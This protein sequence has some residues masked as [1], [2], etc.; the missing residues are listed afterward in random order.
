MKHSQP[1]VYWDTSAIL[2]VLF[3]D[4][5][6]EEAKS[7]ADQEGVHLI[8]SLGYSEACAVMARIKREGY[9]TDILFTSAFEVLETGPWRRIHLSPAWKD[10]HDL[11]TKWPLRGADLWH[12]ATAKRIQQ[13]LPELSVFSFDERLKRAAEGE[14]L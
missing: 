6:S 14:G 1:V 8:S 10:L 11:C 2:S 3:H 13:E 12:L 9:L 5:H 4:E 7:L